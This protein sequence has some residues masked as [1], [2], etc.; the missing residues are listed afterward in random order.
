MGNN[1]LCWQ[2]KISEGRRQEVV[3]RISE[4]GNLES[5]RRPETLEVYRQYKK[6]GRTWMEGKYKDVGKQMSRMTFRGR[7]SRKFVRRKKKFDK[8]W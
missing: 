6:V 1:F 4:G 3:I 8:Q 7:N 5:S 2:N